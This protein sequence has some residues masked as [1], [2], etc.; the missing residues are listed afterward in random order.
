MKKEIDAQVN[1]VQTFNSLAPKV[2]DD[3]AKNKVASLKKQAE[4][5]SDPDKKAALLDEASKWAPNGSYSVA[6]NVII[7]AAGGNL[8]SA[9]AK[10]TLSWA[11]NEMRLAM[12]KDSE[13]FKG[14]CDAV[15]N[16]ISNMSGQSVGVNGDGNKIAGGRIVLSDWCAEGRCEKDPTTKSGYVENS[17]GIVKFNP[18][19]NADGSPVTLSQFMDN[20]QE[21]RSPLGGFQGDKGQMDIF[22]I[23]F[24]Y[25]KGSFW[26]KLAEAY[27]GTHDTFNS[28][29]W[30]DKLGNAQDIQGSEKVLGEIMNR[31]NVGVATPFALSVLL[32]P[33][34]WN[35][36]L[37]T[38]NRVK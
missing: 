8:D 21:W 13:K 18:G 20:H 1:I 28:A 16:C 9:V 19:L 27:A 30:Y 31:V 17:D 32:P 36:I 35:T 14:L 37:A 15:G 2:A 34:V 23:K 33:E 5:E 22:G 3:Y 24:E 6:M 12:I 4:T 7:G 10:E 29:I 11:A 26:D 38:S 25:E